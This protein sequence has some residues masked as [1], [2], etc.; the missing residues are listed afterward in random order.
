[1]KRLP[2]RDIPEGSGDAMDGIL[3]LVP[4]ER[5]KVYDVRKVISAIVDKDSLFELKPDYGKT[6][7]TAFTRI[8]GRTVGF[9]ANNPMFKGGAIDPDGCNKVT[10]FMVLCDSFNIPLVL[11]VDVPGFLIGV[12]GER[13]GAPGRIMNWMNALQLVTVPKFSIILRITGRPIS[14]WVA[15]ATAMKSLSGHRPIL[16][17]WTRA[18]AS[19][20]STVSRGTTTPKSSTAGCRTRSGFRAMGVGG[21]L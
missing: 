6:A 11:L 16:V 1:M 9:I 17:L 21:A 18:S 20:S 10:S 15:V 7:T 2:T 19:M 12:E 4:E 13:I 14:I 3:D 8:A 5:Q